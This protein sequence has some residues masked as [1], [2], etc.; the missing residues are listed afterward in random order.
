MT[1]I[2]SVSYMCVSL[3]LSKI[4]SQL[5]PGIGGGSQ[6]QFL[7]QRVSGYSWC[8]EVSQGSVSCVLFAYAPHHRH[9]FVS[10]SGMYFS[11]QYLSLSDAVVIKFISPILTGFSGAIFLKEPLSHR[12]ILAGCKFFFDCSHHDRYLHGFSIQFF[13]CSSDRQASNFIWWF[14]SDSV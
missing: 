9:R 7:A 12:E 10:L 5:L 13:W 11:L 6:T 4:C 8:S 1:Y 2:C 14:A 3:P